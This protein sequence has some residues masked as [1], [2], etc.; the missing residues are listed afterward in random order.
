M[1]AANLNALEK[2]SCEVKINY[3]LRIILVIDN[4]S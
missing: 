3:Q 2:D 4:A 1:I